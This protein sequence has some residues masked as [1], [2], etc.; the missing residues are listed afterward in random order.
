MHYERAI[1]DLHHTVELQL[2][3]AG[4]IKLEKKFP[5]LQF[6]DFEKSSSKG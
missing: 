4:E 1:I 5:F 2:W 3:L 6:V